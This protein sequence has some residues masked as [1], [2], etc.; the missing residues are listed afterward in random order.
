MDEYYFSVDIDEKRKLCL[1]PLTN[2]LAERADIAI[3]DTSGYY[4][5]EQEGTIENPF[6]KILAHIISEEGLFDLR[7]RFQMA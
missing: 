5:Y 2:R 6:I 1:S 4:L 3:Q 7:D